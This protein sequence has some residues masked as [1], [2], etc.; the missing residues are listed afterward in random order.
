MHFATSI[1]RKL[2]VSM[3]RQLYDQWREAILAGRFR[4]GERVPSTRDL[5]ASLSISRGT[6][7]EAWD[8]LMA[9]GYLET[10]QGSGTF[11]CRELP[12]NLVLSQRTNSAKGS[13]E[14][15]VRLSRYGARL[16]D[17]WRR[18]S[19][20]RAVIRFSP[21]MPDREHFPLA[22]WRRLMGQQ[23]RRLAPAAFGYIERSAGD[24]GLRAEIASYVS[25]LRAVRCVPEQI[26]IVSGSQQGLDLSA[27]LLIEAGDQVAFE[28]PGYQGARHVFAAY[29]AR[30]RALPIDASGAVI[31]GLDRNTRLVYITPS[32]QYPTGVSMSLARR[33]ELIDWAKRSGAVI[34]ED[35][36]CSEYRYS[37]P[38]LPSLQGMP[39]GAAVIYIG[40]FSKVM[41]PGLRIGYI[42]SP[43]SLVPF[44]KRA[45]WLADTQTPMLEQAALA[46]FVAEGHLERHIRRM[47]RLYGLRRE[48][49]LN[50]LWKH[51]NDG[52]QPLGDAAGM[53]VMVRFDDKNVMRRAMQNKVELVSADGY[54]LTQPPGNEFIFGFSAL[55]ERAIQEG[56]RRLSRRK[57]ILSE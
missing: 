50:S 27:R 42:I 20:E 4:A 49:L 7:S 12:D 19:S 39:S 1:D 56:I 45:K 46:K 37:G 33:F 28:N 48:A 11:V 13:G 2:S 10:A 40:T 22:L 25:R 15:R 55:P 41:F 32:H 36:Y 24:E 18:V 54:Y 43:P 29:G 8:Q 35:D 51:F 9:E 17:D 57:A 34:V 16:T 5:A 3:Q 31:R 26:I 53:H 23:T 30:L 38:P 21:G 14:A 6:V 44:F 52:A 47:R